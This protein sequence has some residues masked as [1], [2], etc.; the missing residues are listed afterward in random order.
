[1]GRSLG[2]AIREALGTAA[3]PLAFNES[4]VPAATDLADLV[5]RIG[6]SGASL[7]YFAGEAAEA[8]RL[9]LELV[10]QGSAALILGGDALAD[11][12]FTEAAGDTANGTLFTYPP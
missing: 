2:G 11:P 5:H 3:I 9:R 7:V 6:E 1:Y 4:Y 10:A 12:A 8:A